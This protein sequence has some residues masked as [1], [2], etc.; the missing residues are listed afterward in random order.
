MNN[1]DLNF[2]NKNVENGKMEKLKCWR[3]KTKK[4]ST[5]KNVELNSFFVSKKFVFLSSRFFKGFAERIFILN[6]FFDFLEFF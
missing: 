2:D 6:F 3:K 4:K 1:F 5:G